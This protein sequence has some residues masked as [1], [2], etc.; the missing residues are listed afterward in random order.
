V[1]WPVQHLRRREWRGLSDTSLATQRP[2]EARQASLAPL[3]GCHVPSSYRTWH[4]G[5]KGQPRR[6]VSVLIDGLPLAYYGDS[7]AGLQ[8]T[9]TIAM[10][11]PDGGPAAPLTL[12]T[13][14]EVVGLGPPGPHGMIHCQIHL[15]G[16][17]G[18]LRPSASGSATAAA[19]WLR[20][21]SC[22]A[23][24]VRRCER[25]RS[26]STPGK[27]VRRSFWPLPLRTMIPRRF[28]SRS[29]TRI[30][31][32]STRTVAGGELAF[33]TRRSPETCRR[34]SAPRAAT[35]RRRR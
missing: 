18:Y 12:N 35:S 8:T 32:F 19:P 11:C 4:P 5:E 26:T 29:F 2:T 21:R 7:S 27:T 10:S 22:S 28:R 34:A 25:S 13:C 24:A 17:F 16:A 23:F 30:G 3:P 31:R 33:G 9:A 14:G 6:P 1:H 15:R 20:S